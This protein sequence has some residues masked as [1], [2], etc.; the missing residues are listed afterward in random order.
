[1][2]ARISVIMAV[3]HPAPYLSQ[4]LASIAGQ[5]LA[6]IQIIVIETDPDS[7]T[8]ANRPDVPGLTVTLQSG[9]GLAQAWNQGLDMATGDFIT[10]LDCD[11]EW[12]LN[13][14]WLHATALRQ[15]SEALASV[16][17]VRFFHEGAELPPGARPELLSGEHVAYMPGSSLVRRSAVRIIGPY[18]ED[19]GVATDIEWFARLRNQGPVAQIPHCVLRKRVHDTNLSYGSLQDGRYQADLV[20]AVHAHLQRR[21]MP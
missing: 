6:P 4:S 17:R 2:T 12:T 8:E 7:A 5:S 20:N 19:L 21:R 11:D 14:L 10:W 3:R 1:M 18:R 16:G 9:T 13:A 15:D